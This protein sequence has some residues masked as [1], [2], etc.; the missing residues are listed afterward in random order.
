MAGVADRIGNSFLRE[1]TLQHLGR[2]L[3]NLPIQ[4]Q[5]PLPDLLLTQLLT[6]ES[7]VEALP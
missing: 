1:N 5:G 3:Q 6:I 4:K 2:Q 7:V